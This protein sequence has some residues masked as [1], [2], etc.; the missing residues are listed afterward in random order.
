MPANSVRRSSPPRLTVSFRSFWASLTSSAAITARHAEIDFGEI[1]D[2]AF[3]GQRLRGEGGAVVLRRRGLGGAGAGWFGA[4][5]AL[6]DHGGD[7]LGVHP[8]EQVLEAA[9]RVPSRGRAA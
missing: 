8:P 3:R 2:R 6:G 7:R 4:D 1:V 9:D 5:R